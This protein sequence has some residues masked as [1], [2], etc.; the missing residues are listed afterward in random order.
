MDS[1]EINCEFCVQGKGGGLMLKQFMN[2]CHSQGPDTLP[3]L[4]LPS[5]SRASCFTLSPPP[6]SSEICP[7]VQHLTLC[8]VVYLVL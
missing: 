8:V 7:W 1:L 4:R 6:K 3:F 2:Q 5:Y